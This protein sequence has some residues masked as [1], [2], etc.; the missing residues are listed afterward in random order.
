MSRTIFAV[1]RL[2]CQC[3]HWDSCERHH[4]WSGRDRVCVC[5]HSLNMRCAGD[6][7]DH[8]LFRCFCSVYFTLNSFVTFTWIAVNYM[9]RAN[10]MLHS[11]ARATNNFFRIRAAMNGPIVCS[12]FSLSLSPCVCVRAVSNR[13][14][15]ATQNKTKKQLVFQCQQHKHT[16]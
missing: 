10:L 7:D 3:S 5:V 1:A 4:L 6:D 2:F 12:R 14:K 11:F 8:V 13:R 16:P 9:V 15:M